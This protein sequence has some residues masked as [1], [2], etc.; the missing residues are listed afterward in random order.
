MVTSFYPDAL[1]RTYCVPPVHF[2]RVPYV[3]VTVPGT[4]QSALVLGRQPA[5]VPTVGTVPPVSQRPYPATEHSLW[6]Q[7]PQPLAKPVRVIDPDFQDDNAH[8]HVMANLQELGKHRQQ[9]MFILSQI[10]W[11]NYLNKKC[12]AADTAQFPR[13]KALNT[14]AI[15]Y[16]DGECDFLLIDRQHGILIGELKS[17]GRPQA[18]VSRT[19]AQADADVAKRVTKAVKQLDRSETVVNHLVSDI[20]PGLAVSKTIFLPYVSRAQ[21][22]QVLAADPQLEQVHTHSHT[23][24]HTHTR[25][26]PP[27]THT[28]YRHHQI[29]ITPHPRHPSQSHALYMTRQ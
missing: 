29:I 1:T 7:E 20:A 13:L 3:R 24:T 8:S 19:P 23:H 2:N 25:T 5:G 26:P 28:H 27:H 21:L 16:S 11:G 12:Y 14:K 4:G 6:T 18:G 15:K 10:L 9:V 22:Q 17:V